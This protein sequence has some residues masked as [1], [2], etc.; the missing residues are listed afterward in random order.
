MLQHNPQHP[1]AAHYAIHAFDSPDHAI[2]ALPAARLYAR[3]APAG[4]HA[5]H[6]PSHMFMQLGMWRDVV[7]SN[8]QAYASVGGVGEVAR[9]H[10]EQVRLALVLVARRGAP[11]ARAAHDARK[12]IDDAP[13]LLVAA[14][15]DSGGAPR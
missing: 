3:I 10:A 9:A 8:E 1:G 15:D 6:M 2:L 4:S 13:A 11:R 12:L 5:L 14:K 7:P